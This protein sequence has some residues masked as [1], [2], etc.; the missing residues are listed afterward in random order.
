MIKKGD[1]V[2]YKQGLT[3][4]YLATSDTYELEGEQ[5]VNLVGYEAVRVD[6]LVVVPALPLDI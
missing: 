4:L 1:T 6:S 3:Q 5:V 2:M